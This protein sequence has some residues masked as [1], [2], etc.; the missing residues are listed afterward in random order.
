MSLSLGKRDRLCTSS[1]MP[2]KRK[3]GGFFFFKK[4]K[5]NMLLQTVWPAHCRTAIASKI[6]ATPL[7]IEESGAGMGISIKLV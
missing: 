1:T 2:H 5:S 7:S 4:K 3:E 6:Q